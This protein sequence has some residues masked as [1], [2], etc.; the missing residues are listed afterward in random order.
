MDY[1]SI[2]DIFSAP[3]KFEQTSEGFLA[4]ERI[5]INKYNKKSNIIEIIEIIGGFCFILLFVVTGFFLL[6]IFWWLLLLIII[7]MFLFNTKFKN[8]IFAQFNLFWGELILS[9]YPLDL[10]G[11]YHLK[12]RRRLRR[13]KKIEKP[14]NLTF[15]IACLEITKR[16]IGASQQRTEVKH[17]ILWESQPEVYSVPN[18]VNMFSLHTNL[19]IPNHLPPSFEG[20]NNYIRWV[21]SIEQN[22]PNIADKVYSQFIVVVDPV[23]IA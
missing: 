3:H 8:N 10:G 2:S 14:G 18:D 22:L 12:F 13:N 21:V 9:T 11:N 6:I 16:E 5:S 23:V 17:N 7:G 4:S 1:S 15:K 19:Q 20:K